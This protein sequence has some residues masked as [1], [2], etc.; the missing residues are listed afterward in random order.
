MSR[1]KSPDWLARMTISGA[2]ALIVSSKPFLRSLAGEVPI[3][4][5]SSRILPLPPVFGDRPVRHPLALL[6]EVRADEGEIVH[7]RLGERRIDAAVD[8]AG[9]ECRPSWRP[10]IAGNERLLLARRQEDEVDALG[11]HAVDVGDLLG[12]RI[13]RVGVDELAAAL[14]G[15]VLHAD[16]LRQSPGIIAY[17]LREADFVGILLFQRRDL[18]E[19]GND[20]QPGGGADGSDEHLSAIDEHLAFLLWD[21]RAPGRVATAFAV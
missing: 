11:D 15:L 18:A 17:D 14:L 1:L 6:D 5:S 19:G 12:R 2:L 21:D 4:P 3:E 7:A 9:P 16:G 13:R 8:Q 10:S 20:R